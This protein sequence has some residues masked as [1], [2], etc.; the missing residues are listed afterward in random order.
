MQK[1]QAYYT[2]DLKF[3]SCAFSLQ[4]SFGSFQNSFTVLFT[5]AHRV[6]FKK[7]K[8]HVFQPSGFTDN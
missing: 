8:A 4:V 3:S 6:L 2:L 5:I 1:I 7:M